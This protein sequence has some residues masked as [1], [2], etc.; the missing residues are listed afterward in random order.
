MKARFLLLPMAVIAVAGC[1]YA[2]AVT[3][4]LTTVEDTL[5]VYSYSFSGLP[6]PTALN[7]FSHLA[8]VAAV[9]NNFDLIFDSARVVAGASGP[10]TQAIA[11]PLKRLVGQGHTGL[12]VDTLPYDQVLAAPPSGYQDSLNVLLRRGTVLVIEATPAQCAGQVFPYTQIYSKIVVDSIDPTP[13]VRSIHFRMRV[14]PNC[15][16]RGFRDGVPGS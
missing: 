3:A 7:T 9:G 1:N 16:F 13:G 15:G 10:D 4:S 2:N 11:L 12:I 8:V 14:D 5:T 6:F